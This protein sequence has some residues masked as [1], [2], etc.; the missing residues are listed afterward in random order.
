MEAKR[1]PGGSRRPLG[2]R[3]AARV[4]LG[5]TLAACCPP[6]GSI[7]GAKLEPKVVKTAIQN[8][9][10]FEVDFEMHF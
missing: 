1:G 6:F 5:A 7:L 4:V 9:S 3:S 8:A 10:A 2:G